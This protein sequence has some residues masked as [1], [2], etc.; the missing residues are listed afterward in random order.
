MNIGKLPKY[1]KLY[2]ELLTDMP[3]WFS[4]K[5]LDLDITN[6]I[7]I[8]EVCYVLPE[9]L[10]KFK[11]FFNKNQD[12]EFIDAKT[13]TS[14][15]A[16][17]SIKERENP[18]KESFNR[19]EDSF[20]KLKI[21]RKNIDL[22]FEDLKIKEKYL[23]TILGSDSG[24]ED[25]Q[26]KSIILDKDDDSLLVCDLKELTDVKHLAKQSKDKLTLEYI[27]NVGIYSADLDDLLYVYDH[28][29]DHIETVMGYIVK[30][31]YLE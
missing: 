29:E 12:F 23:T 24:E 15:G 1:K 26:F 7:P 16:I 3:A 18:I 22:K 19:N 4:D 27:S 20:N 30:F 14:K 25:F 10:K 21:G 8:D 5:I 31:N 17:L 2:K 9:L 28:I 11:N 6:E 13:Y